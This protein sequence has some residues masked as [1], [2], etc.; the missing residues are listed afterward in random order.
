M[1]STDFSKLLNT[2]YT[3]YLVYCHSYECSATSLVEFMYSHELL[4]S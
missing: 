1:N 2:I 4:Q 3:V